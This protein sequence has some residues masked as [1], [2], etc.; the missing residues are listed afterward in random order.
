MQGG[1]LAIP[2]A[3]GSPS[4]SRGSA[5][6]TIMG[7]SACMGWVGGGLAIPIAGGYPPELCDTGIQLLDTI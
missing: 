4:N 5:L 7:G 6:N 3:G 1:G 2:I